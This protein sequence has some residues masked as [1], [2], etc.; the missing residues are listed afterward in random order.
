MGLISYSFKLK[1]VFVVLQ[2]FFSGILVAVFVKLVTV[3]VNANFFYFFL[4]IRPVLYHF[5][6]I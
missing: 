1:S 4:F 2:K 3:G 5:F 6:S